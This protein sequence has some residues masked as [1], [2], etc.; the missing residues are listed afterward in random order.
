MFKGNFGVVELTVLR[1]F[2]ASTDKKYSHCLQ[3]QARFVKKAPQ[4]YTALPYN[5][6]GTKFGMQSQ[7]ILYMP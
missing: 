5:G 6:I 4:Q 7:S 3:T 2:V 1:I